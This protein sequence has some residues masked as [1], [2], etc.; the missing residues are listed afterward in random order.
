[1]T[2]GCAG[3]SHPEHKLT[4][5]KSNI[6]QRPQAKRKPSDNF[7][8]QRNIEYLTNKKVFRQLYV[9]EKHRVPDEQESLK[10]TLCIRETEYLTY[11]K[12]SEGFLVRQV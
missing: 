7:M 6:T 3:L 5:T 1:M 2:I 10:T 4:L 9:S 11:I 12:L 8:Y